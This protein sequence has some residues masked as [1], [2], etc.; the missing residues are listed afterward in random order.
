MPQSSSVEA[1]HVGPGT[2]EGIKL[3]QWVKTHQASNVSL[4][5]I[6]VTNI[7][8]ITFPSSLGSYEKHGV[9]HGTTCFSW[10][11]S[12]TFFQT[13][14]KPNGCKMICIDQSHA[15]LSG[16]KRKK[17][18]KNW[19]W[20]AACIQYVRHLRHSSLAARKKIASG[21]AMSIKMYCGASRR[22][23]DGLEHHFHSKFWGSKSSGPS[24]EIWERYTS[25]GGV[26]R[27][28]LRE[29]SKQ[30]HGGMCIPQLPRIS[31]CKAHVTI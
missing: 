31:L 30:F 14:T 9:D 25:D 15:G 5:K 21:L 28:L 6:T 23:W 22:T 7:T 4:Q 12:K 17:T 3:V 19:N 11:A 29:N 13:T 10:Q 2:G 27:Q 1:M 16:K 24:D 26:D 20:N 18:T 8:S